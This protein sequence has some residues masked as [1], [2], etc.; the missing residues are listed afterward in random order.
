MRCARAAAARCWPTIR[1]WC[2]AIPGIWH[3]VEIDAPGEHVAG[4]AI[5]GVPGVILGHNERLAWGAANADAVSA[6]VFAETF[7][8]NEGV[9][10]RAGAG[11]LVAAVRSETFKDRFGQ[12]HASR[13]PDDASRLRARRQ[14]DR[15]PCGAVGSGRRHASRRWPR[16]SRSI[17]P[18]RSKPASAHLS[19]YP[20]PTQNFTLAQ[21]DG[22]AAYTIAGAIPDDPAWGRSVARGALAGAA[23]DVRA[24]RDNCRTSRRRGRRSRSTPTTWPTARAI[25]TGSP[26]TS[27][28]RIAPPR[29]RAACTRCRSRPSPC[30]TTSKPTRL[31]SPKPNSRAAAS[32]R[33]ARAARIAIP[34]SRPRYAALAAFDG[35]FDA[36]SR[37]ATVIQRVRF[38][39]TRD[40]I[41]AHM[42]AATAQGYLRDGPAFVTLMRALREHPP[43]WFPHDDADAFLV[44][45]VRST[46]T[47]FGGRD[48]VATPYGTAYAVVAE[49]PFAAFNLHFWDAPAF[50]GSGGSYAPAVQA[51]AL[52]QSFRAVWDVGTGMRAASICRWASRANRVRRTTRTRRRRGCATTSRRCRSV[53]PRST[54]PQRQR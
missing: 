48:A 30:R 20:G 47:L 41:A 54:A 21:T 28:R 31:R 16:F 38:V 9:H 52:G 27:A 1:I 11:Q 35:R 33:C 34:T 32:R 45:S 14:R 18:I 2:G 8:N 4:A 24:V 44:A 50:P 43:G 7:A 15:A 12:A 40:L 17:A 13:L 51:I 49:H 19:A 3:L 42:S 39:A 46:V 5:A 29:S 10:Y 22:R 37:G 26:P 6:R 53:R 25:R 36:G 23:A